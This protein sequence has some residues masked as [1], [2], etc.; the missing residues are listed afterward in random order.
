MIR[1]ITLAVLFLSTAADPRSPKIYNALITSNKNLSPSHAQP[2]YEPV[3]RTTSLGYAFPSWF[4]HTSFVQGV[5]TSYIHPD[6]SGLRKIEPLIE[7]DRQVPQNNSPQPGS[8]AAQDTSLPNDP[9]INPHREP[10]DIGLLPSTG[11]FLN[12]N[13]LYALN[14]GKY[15]PKEEEETDPKKVIANLKKNSDIPDVPPPPLPFRV[16]KKEKQ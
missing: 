5:P 7:S 4:Y 14:F 6:Y 15:L 13:N 2:V 11:E 1:L 10:S 8:L 16:P 3:I 12:H 9:N